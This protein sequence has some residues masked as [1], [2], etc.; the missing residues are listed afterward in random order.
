[1]LQQVVFG[2]S[3]NADCNSSRADYTHCLQRVQFMADGLP[4]MLDTAPKPVADLA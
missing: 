1:M 3:S 2:N 4:G